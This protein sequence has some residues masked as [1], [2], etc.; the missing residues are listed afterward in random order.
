MNVTTIIKQIHM[1]G[2]CNE[3]LKKISPDY[4]EGFEI[5]YKIFLYR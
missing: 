5:E 4:S 2:D 1:G 3:I